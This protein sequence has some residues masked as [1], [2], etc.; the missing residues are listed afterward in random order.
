[1]KKLIYAA[2]GLMALNAHA[3]VWISCGNGKELDEGLYEVQEAQ[4]SSESNKFKGAVGGTWHLKIG[5]GD[6]LAP[7][8]NITAK[9]TKKDGVTTVEVVIKIG[10]TPSG[11]AGTRYVLTDIYSEE[12]TLEKFN[13]SGGFGGNLKVGTF[14]C[15][16]G[17]D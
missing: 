16:S 13:L 5:N 4:F 10:N 6:W 2:I 11:P 15:L 7:H 17:N 1:M 14:K 8:R 12:P 9:S 3:A